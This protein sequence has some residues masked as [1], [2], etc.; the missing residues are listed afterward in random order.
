MASKF[1][2]SRL[3]IEPSVQ[4]TL[5]RHVVIYWIC[6]VVTVELLNLTRQIAIGPERESFW[7]YL[8]NEDLT[9]ALIRLAIGSLLVLPLVIWDMLKLSNRF[10]GPIYRMRRTLRG[11]SESGTVENVRLREG[12]F[13][14]DFAQEL[15]AALSQLDAQRQPQASSDDA[16]PIDH[17]AGC[18]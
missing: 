9:Q 12:D 17:L 6:T 18:K 16:Q 15:N 1:K 14:A 10:A 8:F 4:L 5:V 11:I 13:W 7:A 3:L 2:R